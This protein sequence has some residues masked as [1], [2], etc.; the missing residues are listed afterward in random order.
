M[1][2]DAVPRTIRFYGE[3]ATVFIPNAEETN[4]ALSLSFKTGP[5]NEIRIINI[6]GLAIEVP[7]VNLNYTDFEIDGE[8][9][10]VKIGS[11]SRELLIDG[12]WYPCSFGYSI[13]VPIGPRMRK[14]TLEGEAPFLDIGS[15][16]RQDLC[17]GNYTFSFKKRAKIQNCNV[18]PRV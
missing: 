18:M 9:H 1:E 8:I 13:D 11:P 5:D 3:E 12:K 10:R 6:D 17:L 7:L 4:E 2:I 15:I 16:P 14:V